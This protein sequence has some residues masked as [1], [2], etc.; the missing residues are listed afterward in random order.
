MRFLTLGT[1]QKDSLESFFAE[2]LGSYGVS[3]ELDI[4][5]NIVVKYRQQIQ[6]GLPLL[7]DLYCQYVLIRKLGN[8][9]YD[10]V[11]VVMRDLNPKLISLIRKKSMGGK[12]VNL[13]PDQMT[14]LGRMYSLSAEYDH[15][16]L[17]DRYLLSRLNR[18]GVR[19]CYF[20]SECY[21]EKWGVPTS[22]NLSSDSVVIFGNI[23]F[24]R[25]LLITSL[26]KR[27]PN[28]DIRVYGTPDRHVRSLRREYEIFPPIYGEH[29][30]NI[31]RSAAVVVNNLHF[32]EVDSANNK[33]FEIIG[34]GGLIL[35]ENNPEMSRLLKDEL[36]FLLWEN[37][38]ELSD[39]IL[40]LLSNVEFRSSLQRKLIELRNAEDWTYKNAV[41]TILT[42][43]GK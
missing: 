9:Q 5:R 42:R 33:F 40:H 30:M 32:A 15:V 26:R 35:N 31:I 13:N 14:T 22:G 2:S 37:V 11:F 8:S 23:Y 39:K 6:N 36:E 16:F 20:W 3:D 27:L 29:K 25:H 7:W 41:S 28:V 4:G 34:C 12:V 17:K 1:F 21:P 18:I 38:E 24:Y 19:N 10:I 43:I